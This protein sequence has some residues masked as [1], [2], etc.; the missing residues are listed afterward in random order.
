[1]RKICILTDNRYDIAE[2]INLPD[3]EVKVISDNPDDE[4]YSPSELLP[5]YFKKENFELVIIV[6]YESNPSVEI[7]KYSK[8]IKIHPSI[9]PAFEQNS[10]IRDAYLAGVKV[11]GVTICEVKQNGI[12]GRIISQYPVLIDNFT[13]YDQLESEIKTLEKILLPPVL[14]SI[15]ENKIF[16]IVDFLRVSPCTKPA[17]SQG[18]CGQKGALLE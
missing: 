17:C 12:F 13:H 14:K 6:D 16:D 11:T 2:S 8:F 10:A 5:K 4:N 1:M 15:F 7:F 3:T 18:C 9:L